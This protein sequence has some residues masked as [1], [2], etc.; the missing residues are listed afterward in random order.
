MITPEDAQTLAW[1]MRDAACAALDAHPIGDQ[2]SDEQYSTIRADVEQALA[3][4]LAHRLKVR[5]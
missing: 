1:A 4:V 5:S 2:L 3:E